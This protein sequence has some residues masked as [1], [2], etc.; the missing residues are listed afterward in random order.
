MFRVEV[1]PGTYHVTAH[2]PGSSSF[3]S[4]AE[5]ATLTVS[6]KPA[7]TMTTVSTLTTQPSGAQTNWQYT[8]IFATIIAVTIGTLMV[9]L[10]R[11]LAK[12]KQRKRNEAS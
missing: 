7:A 12:T 11:R 10:S 6:R 4:V 1:G 2:Y 8:A 3:C 9:S 5:T